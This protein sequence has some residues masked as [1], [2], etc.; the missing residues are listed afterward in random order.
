MRNI[1]TNNEEEYYIEHKK[2]S[3]LF[4]VR[5]PSA[6]LVAV[7]AISFINPEEFLKV[8]WLSDL[9]KTSENEIENWI[10]KSI[11]YWITKNAPTDN[12]RYYIDHP[13]DSNLFL[14]RRERKKTESV[15]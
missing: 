10:V 14:I 5:K 6:N 9:N 4:I 7:K 15:T 13:N 8:P 12:S 11:W 2:D 3:S 1:Q